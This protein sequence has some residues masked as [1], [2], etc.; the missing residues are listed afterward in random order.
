MAGLIPAGGGGGE[1]VGPGYWNT[2]GNA[3]VGGGEGTN[4]WGQPATPPAGSHVSDHIAANVAAGGT[5][6]A[7]QRQNNIP[8]ILQSSAPALGSALPKPVITTPNINSQGGLPAVTP[9]ALP[10]WQK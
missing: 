5:D 9:A 3:G 8:P 4:T 7:V 2:T 10:W 1:A 6:H